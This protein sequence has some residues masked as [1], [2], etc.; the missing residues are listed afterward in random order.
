MFRKM[1]AVALFG[2]CAC[3]SN[4][5]G[6]G[7]AGD[8]GSGGV[9]ASGGV[10][11]GTGGST[12]D[13]AGGSTG[14]NGSGGTGA[15]GTGG[16]NP[17]TG[18]GIVSTGGTFVPATGHPF[19][20]LAD[21]D[22]ADRAGTAFSRLKSAVDDVVKIAATEPATATYTALMD[23]ISPN[24]YGYSCVDAVVLYR[25]TQDAKYI[26]HAITLMDAFVNE[27]TAAINSN[28][29][30]T[31][32]GDSYLGVGELM[33]QVALAYDYGY[34]MLTAAQR[35]AWEAYANQAI[36]NVW[37]PN[38]AKWGSRSASW[39]GWSID[40][41]G[42]NYYYSFM[43]ATLLWAIATQNTTWLDFIKTKKAPQISTYFSAMKGGGSREGTGYGTS[44]GSLFE[45]YRYW[46]SSTGTDLLAKPDHPRETIDY[47]VHATVPTL[48]YFASIG[49]QARSSMTSMFDYQRKLMI[50][51]VRLNPNTTEGARGTWWLNHV[52]VMDG[53][54]DPILGKMAYGFDVRFDLL[55]NPSLP[56]QAPADLAYYAAGTGVMFARSAW[57]T[58][59]S[60][61]ATIAGIYD[62]SHAHQDQGSFSI[63]KGTWLAA[64]SNLVSHSGLHAETSAHNLLRFEDGSGKLVEQ[65]NSTST[66]NSSDAD[67]VLTIDEDLSPAYAKSGG[68]VT[69]WKRTLVYTRSAHK[70]EVHDTCVV[71]TNIKPVFQVISPVLT[72]APTV[73][74]GVV[75]MG[76]LKVTQ[77]APAVS[78]SSAPKVVSLKSLPDA[79]FE[80]GYRLDLTGTG[81]EFKVTLE[82]M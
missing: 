65:H 66:M 56:E 38:S 17:G 13:G 5:G 67:G 12:I 26:K 74:D 35:Q 55:A 1:L 21:Y 63:Y 16:S 6:G 44:L 81:C 41:P 27:E 39:S 43:K 19:I 9:A 18:G 40:D 45:D 3:N 78:G 11:D 52:P 72:T 22:A 37:N 7:T 80:S 24:H 70:L 47:W 54:G 36:Q 76:K 71:G 58:S 4:S 73:S 82:A 51:A 33:E 10:A 2:A 14:G 46:R 15:G 62:Q 42:D 28:Q 20:S 30:P 49:D 59:A 53:G 32:A 34:S 29:N 79:E 25:L 23:K 60:W 31:I 57:A 8:S 50:E 48:D 61:L 75:T 69:S 77:V 68:A 64:T